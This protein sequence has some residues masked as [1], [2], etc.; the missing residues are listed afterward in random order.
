MVAARSRGGCLGE[1]GASPAPS[2]PSACPLPSC[3]ITTREYCEFMHGYFHEEATLCSQVSRA[4]D[5][6]HDAS[7]WVTHCPAGAKSFHSI[8]E[9]V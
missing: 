7:S 8:L 4:G 9:W 1:E 5:V 3:E 2:E 6:G